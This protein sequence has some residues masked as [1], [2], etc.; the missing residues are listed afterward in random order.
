MIRH[1]RYLATDTILRCTQQDRLLTMSIAVG[2]FLAFLSG[3]FIAIGMVVQR[4]AL[5]CPTF[6]VP[7][8]RCGRLTRPHAWTLGFALYMLGNVFMTGAH[9]L[10]LLSINSTLNILLVVWNLL[11]ARIYLGEKVTPP[12][13][14]GAALILIGAPLIC[15]GAPTNAKNEFSVADIE[16]LI[17]TAGGATY[18][19]LTILA[20]LGTVMAVLW[21]ER[22]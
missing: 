14:V 15:L 2:S 5:V 4:Y 18:W 6:M 16:G 8:G 10:G 22:A 11:F 12:R 19:L 7:L 13:M 1:T 20:T 9:A 21:F 17:F 3:I